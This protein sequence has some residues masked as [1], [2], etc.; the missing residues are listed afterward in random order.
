MNFIGVTLGVGEPYKTCAEYACKEVEKNLNLETRLITDEHL[1]LSLGSSQLEKAWSLKFRIFDIYP[2]LE[3]VMFFDCDWR[4]LKFFNIE[5]FCPNRNKAYFVAD[6]SDYW[7]IQNLEQQYS[8]NPG[9]YVNSGWFVVNKSMHKHLFEKCRTEYYNYPKSFYGEQDMF[10]HI[11]HNEIVLADK[12]LNV[13]D[14]HR[15]PF[16]EIIGLHNR[17]ENHKFYGINE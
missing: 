10:N 8:F 17:E 11:F 2:D 16:D 14:V 6:R 9:T 1:D 12:R 13:Q 5:E 3:H 4:P 7:F 15:M